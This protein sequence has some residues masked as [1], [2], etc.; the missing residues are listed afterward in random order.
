MNS[1]YITR[2]ERGDVYR[3]KKI[4]QLRGVYVYGDYQYGTVWGLRYENGQL[5]QDGLLVKQ[6]PARNISSF[7]EDGDGEIYALALSDGKIYQLVA[8]PSADG[9][10]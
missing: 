4:P 5:T 3:G 10:K 8:T 6:N 7:A 1:A 9:S 2:A